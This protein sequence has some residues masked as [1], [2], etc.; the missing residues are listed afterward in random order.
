M[1][2]RDYLKDIIIAILL[3]YYLYNIGWILDLRATFPMIGLIIV[4]EMRIND[5][6]IYFKK[7]WKTYKELEREEM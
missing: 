6:L 7:V 1:R 2:I 4:L 5:I 3:T